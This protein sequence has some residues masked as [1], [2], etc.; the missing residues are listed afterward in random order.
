M[1]KIATLLLVVVALSGCGEIKQ[2]PL[3]ERTKFVGNTASAAILPTKDM[4]RGERPG[5][6]FV[7]V[8]TMENIGV[9]FPAQSFVFNAVQ[10]EK[11]MVLFNKFD[12]WCE[13][14]NRERVDTAQVKPEA[15]LMVYTSVEP[16]EA[17]NITPNFRSTNGGQTCSLEFS[18]L[19][20]K[21]NF[22]D[23]KYHDYPA[24]YSGMKASETSIYDYRIEGDDARKLVEIFKEPGKYVQTVKEQNAKVDSLF[25]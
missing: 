10:K 17:W 8:D 16:V 7:Q 2:N 5:R 14:A 13:I 9:G 12:E 18:L 1:K 25:K 21:F 3:Y 19:Q 24:F 4:Q 15:N 6:V 20:S 11:L 23:R 22:T